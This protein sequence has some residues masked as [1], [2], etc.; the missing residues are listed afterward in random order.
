[1]SVM[2]A[3]TEVV[4][5]GIPCWEIKTQ[6]C[7]YYYDYIGGGFAGMVDSAGHDWISFNGGQGCHGVYRG[8]PNMVF[9]GAGGKNGF[10]PGHRDN[11]ACIST[12]LDVETSSTAGAVASFRSQQDNG[13]SLRWDITECGVLAIVES[14]NS[15]S[16]EYFFQYEGTP[17]GEWNPEGCLATHSGMAEGSEPKPLGESWEVPFNNGWA[18]IQAA[19]NR[20]S[21]APRLA[22][23]QNRF[24]TV[25]FHCHR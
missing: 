8:I 3:P 10:H 24:V 18:C 14:V 19:N 23:C 16:P 1:M 17:G 11:N 7:I 9:R 21:F 2:T 20:G 13:W 6:T 22:L 15:D 25:I 12:W 4:Y 5:N